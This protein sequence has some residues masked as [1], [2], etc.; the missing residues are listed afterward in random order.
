MT[1]EEMIND[2]VECWMAD[3]NTQHLEE[4]ARETIAARYASN[5]TDDQLAEEYAELI[6]ED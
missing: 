6:G 2:L 1:R 5:Y 3:L 4:I